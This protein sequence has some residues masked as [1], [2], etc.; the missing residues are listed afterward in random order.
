MSQESSD[1]RKFR[2]SCENWTTSYDR[3]SPKFAD[4]SFMRY[5]FRRH[6][7]ISTMKIRCWMGNSTVEKTRNCATITPRL[8]YVL[9][10]RLPV[11]QIAVRTQAI[12]GKQDS[13]LRTKLQGIA[14][15]CTWIQM[16]MNLT[17]IYKDQMKCLVWKC[18]DNGVTR[19]WCCGNHQEGD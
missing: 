18:D 5:F 13:V 11:V 2:Y 12:I 14:A 16:N 17:R 6:V 19:Q 15:H 1:S 9:T 8:S 4:E 3:T 7:S 10:Y